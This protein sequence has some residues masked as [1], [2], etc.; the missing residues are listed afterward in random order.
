MSL[1]T[2][3]EVSFFTRT[4]F[5]EIDKVY[6]CKYKCGAGRGNKKYFGKRI[7]NDHILGNITAAD[8]QGLKCYNAH[9]KSEFY[10]Y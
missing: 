3:C 10:A 2:Y 6:K 1:N 9:H 8:G 5:S 7:D 4:S